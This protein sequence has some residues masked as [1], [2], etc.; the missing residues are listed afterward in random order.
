MACGD[1][2]FLVVIKR[3][4]SLQIQLMS[5]IVFIDLFLLILG[6]TW[7]PVPLVSTIINCRMMYLVCIVFINAAVYLVWE[8]FLKVPY[9]RL[10]V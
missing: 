10:N 6:H 8:K 9:I 3:R 1:V 5:A 7:D 4:V 2:H